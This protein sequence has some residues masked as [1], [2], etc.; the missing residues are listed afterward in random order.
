MQEEELVLA[1]EALRILGFRSVKA[2]YQACARQ[3]VPYLRLSKRRIRFV[4]SELK[5]FIA[6]AAEVNGRVTVEQALERV[7]K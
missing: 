3:E 5:R 4:R 1:P 6:A 2:L 7:G